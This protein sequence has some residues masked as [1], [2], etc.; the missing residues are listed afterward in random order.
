MMCYKCL[1]R[2]NPGELIYF[3]KSGAGLKFYFH[4]NC[5]EVEIINGSLEV[6]R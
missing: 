2:I 5:D 1:K 6:R 4:K 3:L